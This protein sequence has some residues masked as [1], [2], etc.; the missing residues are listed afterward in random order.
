LRNFRPHRT[1]I[2]HKFELVKPGLVP[3]RSLIIRIFCRNSDHICAV[4]ITEPRDKSQ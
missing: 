4:I 3:A 2:E 1:T